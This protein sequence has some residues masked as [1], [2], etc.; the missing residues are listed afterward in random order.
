MRRF[1]MVRCARV[2]VTFSSNRVQMDSFQTPPYN[3]DELVKDTRAAI[4]DGMKTVFAMASVF[5]ILWIAAGIAAFVMSIMCFG[6]SGTG[7]QHIIGVL[8]AIFFGPFYWIYYFAVASYCRGSN[9]KKAFTWSA[10]RRA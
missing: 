7:A 4:S 2:K 10:K 3:A 9:G 5:A 1:D 6:K 8:L